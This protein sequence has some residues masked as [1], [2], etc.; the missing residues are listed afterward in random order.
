MGIAIDSPSV[1]DDVV[2]LST[3]Q[4]IG[5]NAPRASVIAEV[6]TKLVRGGEADNFKM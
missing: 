5:F 1:E 2:I 6:D 3:P 4:R